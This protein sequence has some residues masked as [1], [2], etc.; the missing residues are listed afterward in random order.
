MATTEN[1]ARCVK[2]VPLASMTKIRVSSQQA[3]GEHQKASTDAYGARTASRIVRYGSDCR[4]RKAKNQG[5]KPPRGNPALQ[6]TKTTKILDYTRL[7]VTR[8][9]DN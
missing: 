6:L 7:H 3:S 5:K 1:I 9:L 2:P 4:K 8:L